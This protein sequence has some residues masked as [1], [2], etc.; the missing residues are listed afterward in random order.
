ELTGA[1][2]EV[3]I[4]AC[5]VADRAAL[6][7][8]LAD[9]EVS[10]VFH[11]AG[12]LDDGV[13]DG[14]TPDR[15]AKVLA[16]KA[17]AARHLDELTRDHPV[18]AF[19]LF[20]SVVGSLGGAGQ[21]NYAAA[22]AYLDALAQLRASAG[23]P[24]TSV[25]WGAWDQAGMATA[26]AVGDRLARGGVGALAPELALRALERAVGA[27]P[28]PLIADLDWSRFAPAFAA[29]RPSPLLSGVREAREAIEAAVANGAN[30]TSADGDGLAAR[31]AGLSTGERERAVLDLVRA[32][33]A[34]VLGHASSEAVAPGR[35]FRDLGFDSLTAVEFR[36]V[37]SVATGLSLPSTVVF[38]YPN[39]GALAEFVC[40]QVW[41]VGV[42]GVVEGGH[43]GG[44]AVEDEPIAIVGMSCR[45]PGG[46]SSPNELWDLLVSGGD[47]IGPFPVD[48]GW[49]FDAL[50]QGDGAAGASGTSYVQEGGFVRGVGDF[51]AELFGISPREAVAM[52]PQQ[53]LLLETSWEAVERAG[54]DPISLRGDRV[55]VFAGTNGQDYAALMSR[56]PKDTEAYLATGN[57][58]SV[59]S[60]RVAYAFGFEGPAVTVD[61]AC[62]SSLVALHW[63]AQALRG[64]ECA[65]ALA[66]GVTVMS[67]PGAFVGFSRQGGLAVDGRV[68]AFAEGADGTGWGEGVGV[69]VLER[70]SD[71]RRNGH[72]VLAVV[73]GSAVNQ[74]GASNGLTAPNGPSQQRVIR[75]ALA[76]AGLSAAEV[77]AV[78]AHGTGTRLGDP[79]EA[80]ALLATYG[81]GRP[82]EQPLWLG[83]IKSNIGHTQ[84]AAGV[85]GVIKMVLAMRHGVLP[86]TL[87]VDAPSSQVDWSSGAVELLTE[88]RA[89]EGEG[90]RVR[91]A[92][93]SS[94]GISG[95]NAHVIV[96][97]APEPASEGDG[98]AGTPNTVEDESAA[99]RLAGVP[100]P[101]VVT[102]KS[103]SA[104]RAQARRLRAFLAGREEASPAAIAHSLINTR[105]GLDHRAAVVGSDR[106]TLLAG[107]AALAEGTPATQVVRGEVSA[108]GG[109]RTAMLFSGQG[110]QRLGMG[111]ELYDRFPV[112]ADAFDAVVEELER[113]LDAPLRQVVWGEDEAEL[114]R[115]VHAQTGLFAVEVALFRLLESF[116]V[117]PDVLIGHSIGELA[118][119]HVAGVLSLADACVLVAAR[120]R[121][122]Q[123]LPEGG[124]MLAVQAREGEIADLLGELVSLAAVNGP[125][126]VVVSGDTDAVEAVRDWAQANGRKSSRLRV[127]HAFHSHR[128][129]GMLDEFA[130]IAGELTYL[131]SRIPVIS[132]LNGEPA[133]AEDLCS[134]SY[135]V[136][137]VREAVRFADAVRT[138]SDAGVTRFVEVGP[139]GVLTALAAGTLADGETGTA[140][141]VATQ[142]ADRDPEHTFVTALAQ[143]HSIGTS[144]DWR[145]LL[146]ER[147]H[148]E[149]PTYAFQHQRYWLD[150]PRAA[151]GPA[152]TAGGDKA[153]NEFWAAIEQQDFDGLANA[154]GTHDQEVLRTVIP[155]LSTWRRDRL[156]QSA[157]DDWYYEVSWSGIADPDSPALT[158]S[159][160]ILAPE[161]EEDVSPTTAVTT[162]A[163]TPLRVA[164]VLRAHG[165][166]VVRV[167]APAGA[168]RAAL[169]AEVHARVG[170]DEVAPEAVAGVVVIASDAV[171]SVTAVQALTDAGVG[172]RI[173][174]LTQRAVATAPS[175]DEVIPDAAMVW[176]LGRSVALELPD[177]W[178]G[179]VDVPEVVDER[180]GRRLAGV[181]SQRVEDQVA[182]RSSGVFG[183]RLVRSARVAGQEEWSIAGGT[184]LVTGGTGALGAQVA[185]WVVERGARRVVLLSRRGERAPGAVELGEDLTQA[186]AEVRIVAC[187]VADRAALAEV[188]ADEK[189]TAVFHTAGVLDDGVV[190][191]LTPERF[192]KVF[193]PKADAARHLD[194]LT[195]DHPLTAFVLFSSMVGT[196]GGPG[197]GNYAAANAYLDAL[198]ERRVRAGLPAT[199][200]AWGP[201]DEAGMAAA[202]VV[203]NRLARGGITALAPELALR[204]LSR[205]ATASGSYAV[206]DVEW[207]RYVPVLTAVRPSPLLDAVPEAQ[208]AMRTG[209][210]EAQTTETS[211]RGALAGASTAER[212]R[213][214]LD[215][216]RTQAAAVLGHASPEA[217]S[218]D[219]PFRELGFDSLSAVEFRNLLTAATGQSLPATVIFDYPTPAALAGQ[220]GTEL[221][222]GADD[223]SPLEELDRLEA[224]LAGADADELTRHKITIRLQALL[225]NWSSRPST[226]H[227]DARDPE[228]SAVAGQFDS[229]SDEELFKLIRED[230]GQG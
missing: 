146:V 112:F 182:V 177:R 47:A 72:Q 39:A 86:R 36:N 69:L 230:P 14:L 10:A 165:A 43:G 108:A 22:N 53:R 122:M 129:D 51:D 124:A 166:N 23:L 33:A 215:L 187:D 87:H 54:I 1:G 113:A 227:G 172:G 37:L 117:V 135:W 147:E 64:G 71:A 155:A 218:A 28:C 131:P 63:A 216:V 94:F 8:V 128:M 111:R 13:V 195:R 154:L 55:G 50:F 209:A 52:D 204:A 205:L 58:A 24:A 101:W 67:T 3:R 125:E 4:V 171:R 46:V 220:L 73:R 76:S 38:D 56:A 27:D 192:A 219:R 80:Q 121:L 20:S 62:S 152:A 199:S 95:T 106:D 179:L 167:G 169:A 77:D 200:I 114:N 180:A 116:G 82:A 91:R 81:Q 214:L 202:D 110:A 19:V 150:T 45:F 6:A 141:C 12:V 213:I 163:D 34:A 212:D 96:E 102:A 222:P 97:Q 221:A 175:D 11:T 194:E 89:W 100:V 85:A 31:L 5:D 119:A 44:L 138:A 16:P 70:L 153:D 93:V 229:V 61:T 159:W 186:G 193:A 198:A 223:G 139:D 7:G 185:R 99:E 109:G 115:T 26:D 149:L 83:S 178:G 105:A 127:S 143:L 57:T 18:T 68:K 156:D 210:S 197:Q 207:E 217:I 211:L 191:G 196:F 123:A 142:R 2:A 157:V 75:Q 21:A 224:M 103:E 74:D 190:D 201:W 228:P 40:G 136:R 206:V 173:W 79:I 42:E 66:G 148:V 181:L 84:A 134:P 176:G 48:R 88:N 145:P 174:A 140:T 118:A 25:A 183:R 32:Q 17:E 189:V 151:A 130:H 92:A 60:G 59:L 107:L 126:S 226:G 9:E 78:E 158:G 160:L 170:A 41:G 30:G 49:N 168:D 184:A 98:V 35:A 120:G 188:L 162:S 208:R 203:E 15:F 65:L 133:S 161:N 137:Q 29:L 225:N 132:T 104:L 144:V 164:E 90:G